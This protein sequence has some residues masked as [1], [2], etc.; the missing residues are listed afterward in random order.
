M[1]LILIQ[2]I[3][4]TQPSCVRKWTLPVINS[5]LMKTN[6]TE[7]PLRKSSVTNLKELASLLLPHHL[8]SLFLFLSQTAFLIQLN[9]N[10]FFSP[11]IHGVTMD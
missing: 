2:I 1:Y 10:P 3:L 11:N 8:V 4:S 9:F 6:M 5:Q 7:N